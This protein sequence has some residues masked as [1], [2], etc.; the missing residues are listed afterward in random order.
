M[1]SPLDGD[2]FAGGL[3]H[4][5]ALLLEIGGEELLVVAAGNEADLL[6]VGLLGE[7]KAALARDLA[8]L[9]L[10]QAAEREERVRELLL[11]EAEEEVGLVLG[12][13]C[14]PLEN[15]ALARRVVLV[16]G[17]VAGGDAVGADGAGGLQKLRRT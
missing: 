12:Q 6:R 1:T 9:G 7:G 15:P 4:G 2:Q 17:V 16:D 10:G 14:G 3:G 8:D 13:I 11:R 5:L